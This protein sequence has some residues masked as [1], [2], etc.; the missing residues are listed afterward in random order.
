VSFFSDG[1]RT[2]SDECRTFSDTGVVALRA[3]LCPP[4]VKSAMRTC[5]FL[6]LTEASCASR[7]NASQDVTDCTAEAVR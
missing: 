3:R 2:I 7:V 1:C 4:T 6:Q 5:H